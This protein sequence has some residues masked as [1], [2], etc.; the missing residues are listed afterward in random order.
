MSLENKGK[1]KA[2]DVS[3][4]IDRNNPSISIPERI[5]V[6]NI[7]PGH[8]IKKRLPLSAS[9]DLKDGVAEFTILAK[10]RRG[11]DARPV[12]LKV[13]TR[14][15]ERPSLEI[16]GYRFNDGTSGFARGNNNGVIESGETIELIAFI[17]NTG[18]GISHQ[19]E[20]T[21][22]ALSSS[23]Q[24]LRKSDALQNIAPGETKQARFA[25]RIPR[26]FAQR[27]LQVQL[28]V[29][30][31]LGAGDAKKMLNIP[32]TPRSPIL[33]YDY[34]IYSHDGVKVN[35][36]SNGSEYI[37]EIVPRNEGDIEAKNVQVRVSVP[38]GTI[39][40]ESSH[41]IP[42][43][44]PRSESGTLRFPLAIPRTFSANNLSIQV[45]MTQD[46]FDPVQNSI[47]LPFHPRKPELTLT[48]TRFLSLA[49]ETTI[50]QG[51]Y[52]ELNIVLQ[53]SGNLEA[54]G[55]KAKILISDPGIDV[56][57]SEFY[58]GNIPP[59][60]TVPHKFRFYVKNSAKP[61]AY[62]AQ[63]VVSQEDGF[64]GMNKSLTLQIAEAGA[65]VVEVQ[66]EE[67]TDKLS[68]PTR[69]VLIGRAPVVKVKARGV[70][71]LMQTFEP[72]VKIEIS[73]E[74]DKPILG[75]EP[76]I[77]VGGRRQ[78]QETLLRGIDLREKE[79]QAGTN[80][81]VFVRRVPLEEGWNDIEVRF[82][83]SDNLEGRDLER[84]EYVSARTNIYALIIGISDYQ[85]NDIE[86]LKYAHKDAQKFYDFLRSESGGK[87]PADNIRL[88]IN[89]E[90][91]R[92]NILR[93]FREI[94]GKA[95][96][97][98]VVY[99]YMAMHAIPDPSGEPLFFL[100]Y[101]SD[102]G[103]LWETAIEES[104]LRT[105]LQS[106]AR[107]NKIIW[108]TDVCHAGTIGTSMIAMRGARASRVNQLLNR[109]AK[110]RNGMALFMAA[111]AN[112]VSQESDK[113]GGGVFT[114]YLIRG[115]RGEADENRDGFVYISELERY[116]RR[117]VPEA[118]NGAQHPEVSGNFDRNLMMGV[119]K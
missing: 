54:R 83:D 93:S 12:K 119:V 34:S 65:Y 107:S 18:V 97:N 117:A 115:L 90:A 85:Q 109:M 66:G 116:I 47:L 73:I 67:R 105:S 69:P 113:W 42:K 44:S 72:F 108:I 101:D 56:E 23:V 46:D 36:V 27:E 24:V 98:D 77:F 9:L 22:E 58:F 61:G 5:E 16:T 4:L 6:G 70:N 78:T 92:G 53:N 45:Q 21:I 111:S 91:T 43:I 79:Q 30:D 87:V 63:L 82:L 25:L 40:R 31:M 11:Y 110:A 26:T 29:Q 68:M 33:V 3:L 39:L 100:A 19:T 7:E 80:R 62:H 71:E 37:I 50:R 59:G 104:G 49:G 89:E 14:H 114:H 64:S 1:G 99:L 20:S 55:V 84:V 102:A 74:D 2:F 48:Q 17:Q 15:L 75:L 60:K 51:D 8:K 52:G 28:S 112:E 96:E 86:R 35:H 81:L 118:T 94:L 32:V 88:L 38:S 57:E 103:N 10:E 106:R 95:L 41:L 76:E 13:R